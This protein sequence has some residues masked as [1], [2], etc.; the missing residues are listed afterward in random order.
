MT[1]KK[2]VFKE[3]GKVELISEDFTEQINNSDEVICKNQY[4]LVS[5]GT[6]LACLAGIE[7]WFKL[8]GTPGYIAVGEVLKKGDNVNN[9]NIAV[10]S[11]VQVGEKLIVQGQNNLKNESKIAY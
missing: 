7:S 6:E 5:P 4:S 1:N 11:G 8:P 10:D 3:P 9:V 2:I